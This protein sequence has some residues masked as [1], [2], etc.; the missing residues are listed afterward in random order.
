MLA[1]HP[2][3][4][5]LI[6]VFVLW[7]LVWRGLALWRAGRRNEPIWFVCLLVFN[8]LGILPIIYLLAS[9]GLSRDNNPKADA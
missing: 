4:A 8:T 6:V 5:L 7:D 1:G 9:G 3:I 2:F